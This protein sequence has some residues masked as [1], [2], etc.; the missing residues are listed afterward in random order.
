[1][2]ETR[3]RLL[4]AR[5]SAAPGR[6]SWTPP[7]IGDFAHDRRILAFDASLSNTGWVVFIITNNR[8]IVEGKG[9]IRPKCSDGGYLGTW[10]KAAFLRRRLG[11]EPLIARY[12]R[13][14]E[15][16][17][18]VEAPVVG[19]GHRKESSLIAG[20]TVWMECDDCEDVSA[21]SVS[22]VLLGDARIRSEVRKPAVKAAV[23]RFVPEA[24]GRDWN[25]H[26]RDGMSVGLV[27][28][29][30]LKQEAA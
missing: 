1:M 15:V 30:K 3:A 27:R 24:A 12:A 9:T 18:A 22:A 25:E 14:P 10:Q 16:L 13:D 11:E 19:G 20:M 21:T 4:E 6:T 17:R 29:W 5:R 26:E 8:V 2:E 28:L 7:V 23:L